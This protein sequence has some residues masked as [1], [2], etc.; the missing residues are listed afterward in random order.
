MGLLSGTAKGH[1]PNLGA[2]CFGLLDTSDQYSKSGNRLIISANF[3]VTTFGIFF[4][5]AEHS[6]LSALT[7]ISGGLLGR[8]DRKIRKVG[9]W[10][11]RVAVRQRLSIQFSPSIIITLASFLCINTCTTSHLPYTETSRRRL[12][13]FSLLGSDPRSLPPPYEQISY[14]HRAWVP[15]RSSFI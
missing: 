5:S 13:G 9:E 4:K 8:R 15:Y 6:H 14:V 7:K 11:T 3:E 12:N 10:R 1:P 2:F